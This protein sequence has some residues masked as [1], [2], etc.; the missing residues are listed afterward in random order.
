MGYVDTSILGG[1]VV[2]PRL[3]GLPGVPQ[4]LLRLLHSR[5]V[6][7]RLV[8]V[9]PDQV[10]QVVDIISRDLQTQ[11]RILNNTYEISIDGEIVE[12]LVEN[13]RE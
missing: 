1:V 6:D 2:L 7:I 8:Q 3:Y 11:I 4:E 5:L 10:N 12:E 9:L 13:A